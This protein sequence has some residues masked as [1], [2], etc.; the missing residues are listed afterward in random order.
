MLNLLKS[1]LYRITRPRGLRGAFWQYTSA[2]T[3]IFVL[4]Y[5]TFWFIANGDF[6]ASGLLLMSNYASPSAMLGAI[7]TDLAP[8]FA[9][10]IVVEHVL[11]DFKE[12]FVRTLVSVRVGRLSY[13]AEKIVV[14]G[15]MAAMSTAVL[16]ILSLAFCGAVGGAFTGSDDVLGLL[17]WVLALWLN[18]WALASLA[19]M[20]AL[21]TRVPV[22]S[23]VM[24]F[25]LGSAV[26]PQGL[27]LVASLISAFGTPVLGGIAQGIANVIGELTYWM[28]STLI[29]EFVTP[30]ASALAGSGLGD[31]AA[32]LPGG[33][34]TQAIAAPVIWI[35]LAMVVTLA[36]SKNREV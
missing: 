8:L 12:G 35:A 16:A 22:L 26:I 18:T 6:S 9:C 4:V 10:F 15:I 14:A 36:A 7:I 27:T 5:I 3:A 33:A 30:G 19:A 20:V 11:A 28:P 23:Y 32:M 31:F 25:C 34:V 21:I 24:A 17:V 29:V 1:D 2:C 13:F